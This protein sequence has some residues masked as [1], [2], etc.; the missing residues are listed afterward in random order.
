MERDPSLRP[1]YLGALA[2]EAAIIVLLVLLQYTF[3]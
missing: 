2:V 3:G 1:S